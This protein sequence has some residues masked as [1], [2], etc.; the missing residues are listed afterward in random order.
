M[1]LKRFFLLFIFMFSIGISF[2]QQL[3]KGTVTDENGLPIPF[4]KE[5]GVC[6]YCL[7]KLET[8]KKTA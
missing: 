3:L 7:A 4:A 5:H 1:Q 6:Y 2:G 8:A